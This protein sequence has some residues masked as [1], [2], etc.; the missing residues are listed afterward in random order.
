TSQNIDSSLV[1]FNRKERGNKVTY[2]WQMSDV[3]KM[4]SSEQEPSIRYFEPHILVRISQYTYKGE[5]VK[6]LPDLEH[7]HKW[8]SSL[9]DRIELQPAETL[10]LLSDSIC[11]DIGTDLEKVKAIYY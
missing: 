10:H 5:V 8:Y 6:V 4:I 11:K 2:T 9:I 3:P 7:L 1:I